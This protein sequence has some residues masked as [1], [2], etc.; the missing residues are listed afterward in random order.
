MIIG[1]ECIHA[2]NN[3][4]EGKE[5]EAAMKLGMS[6]AYERVEWIF[7]KRIMEKLSFASQWVNLS[8]NCVGNLQSFSMEFLIK[9]LC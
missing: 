6:K 1:F 5:G 2:I 9:N 3:K 7:I 8:I 4:G